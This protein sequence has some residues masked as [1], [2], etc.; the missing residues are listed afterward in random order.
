MYHFSSRPRLFNGSVFSLIIPLSTLPHFL[1]EG[2]SALER[3]LI[4]LC[5]ALFS[6]YK[7]NKVLSISFSSQTLYGYYS[8]IINDVIISELHEY[9]MSSKLYFAYQICF[10]TFVGSIKHLLHSLKYLSD[11]HFFNSH[12][13]RQR[14]NIVE[15]D[16]FFENAQCLP[17]PCCFGWHISQYT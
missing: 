5:A 7:S 1:L 11:I 13:F 2:R 14:S 8:N 10:A 3:Y 16:H 17:I 4:F 15:V 9:D 12:S 6:C